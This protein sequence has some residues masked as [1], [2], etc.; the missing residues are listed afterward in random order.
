L[1]SLKPHWS[2][3]VQY[4]PLRSTSIWQLPHLAIVFSFRWRDCGKPIRVHRGTT[5]HHNATPTVVRL[6]SP[7]VPIAENRISN[8]IATRGCGCC[9]GDSQFKWYSVQY[10]PISDMKDG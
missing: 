4:R 1:H 9:E 2:Q 8:G 10:S 5:A 3:T 7:R 6:S